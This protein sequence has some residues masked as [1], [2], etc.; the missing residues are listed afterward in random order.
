MITLKPWNPKSKPK[1]VKFSTFDVESR[2]WINEVCCAAAWRDSQGSLV[3]KHFK[4][5]YEYIDFIFTKDHSYNCVYIHGGGIFD[6]DFI[7]NAVFNLSEEYVL[8]ENIQRSNGFLLFKICKLRPLKEGERFDPELD[9]IRKNKKYTVSRT[10]EFRDSSALLPF[11]L[12]TLSK[13]FNVE[14]KK[15][16]T[17]DSSNITEATEEVKKY[18]LYDCYALLEVMEEFA[19]WPL[20]KEVG[21]S[22]TM[23]G[24]SLKV[25]RKYLHEEIPSL[26]D[27]V[28]RFIRKGYFGGRTEIF[29]SVF[30]PS[31]KDELLYYY[32]YN[33]LYPSCMLE[34]M[35]VYL[36]QKKIKKVSD[37]KNKMAFIDCD[38]EVPD[39]YV[40]PLP[41]VCDID[42]TDKLI[43]PVGTFRGVFS[44]I[45]LT[46]A[47]ECGVKINKIYNSY[48]FE[49]GGAIFYEYIMDMY[50]KRKEASDVSATNIICKL[51][52]NSLYGRWG[53]NKD[54]TELIIN[55]IDIEG[56][57]F[58][59]KVR[60]V[61][62]HIEFFESKKR[63]DKSFTNVAVAAWV[64]SLARIKLHKDLK[65]HHKH[66]FYCDT[67]SIFLDKNLGEGSKE[68]GKL[69][70]ELHCKKALFLLPKSYCLDQTSNP[71]K[72]KIV[73]LKGMDKGKTKNFIIMD[74]VS[75]FEG[76]HRLRTGPTEKKAKLRT[77]L[78][79][80]SF[81]SL[82]Y[83]RGRE[84]KA[85]Y[86][87][88]VYISKKGNADTRPIY[89]R[90]GK[91]DN[92]ETL[93]LKNKYSDKD[94]LTLY[95]DLQ[96]HQL[97]NQDKG[98]V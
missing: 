32:D 67:D 8:G 89:L 66:I 40:P 76:G 50:K 70:K 61:F 74:F 36:T 59:S 43:F 12:K 6:F 46:H 65:K 1:D 10:I 27:S 35:P 87:K 86:D 68:L 3:G 37:I 81:L 25:F 56:L 41:T 39:M 55:P 26:P 38:V 94:S 53:L 64:T 44:S 63:L 4:D 84:I 16:E 13:E 48:V 62:G 21:V 97:V 96:I 77:A 79:K 85:V 14:H 72:R 91:I 60:T 42:G 30:K 47:M 29:K 83:E 75:H 58:H 95:D 19:S 73:A 9:V 92:I 98:R 52:M 57:K 24:Q 28:D 18:N 90:N 23:A 5:V 54:R 49:S 20:I 33:S 11:P 22:T 69:K 82:S 2:G 45:E 7:L 15:I 34:E 80:G 93:N 78:K 88:R 51:L 31:T 71:K 17:V